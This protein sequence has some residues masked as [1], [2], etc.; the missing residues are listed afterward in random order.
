[1]GKVTLPPP[2]KVPALRD[3]GIRPE[4]LITWQPAQLL[5]R[6]HKTTGDHPVPWDRMRTFGPILR[7]DHHPLPRGE[8]PRYGI[9]Y[10]ASDPRGGL[11]E[12]FQTTRVIDRR[13][14]DPYLTGLRCTRPL[15]LLDVSGIGG[16]AWATRVGGNH[17]LDSAAHGLSQHWARNIHRAHDNLDGIIY[18]GRFAGSDCVA[19]FERAA[20]AF[21][22]HPALSLPLAHRALDGKI[23]TAAN[24]LGYTFI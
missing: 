9:W 13:Y 17:A 15:T 21:P 24:G 7:F 19:L 1:M 10:G 11:A 23:A 14:R 16:A 2:P 20:D 18:R 12:A 4:E 3:A 5:W 8:Y 6:V 22:T